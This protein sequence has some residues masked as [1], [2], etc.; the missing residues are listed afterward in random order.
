LAVDTAYLH[1]EAPTSKAPE[2]RLRIESLGLGAKGRAD[3]RLLLPDEEA[4]AQEEPVSSVRR[5][6]AV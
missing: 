4:P 6:R 5:M 2:V 3:R 1:A